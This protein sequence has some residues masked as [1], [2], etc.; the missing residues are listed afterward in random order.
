M[1][2]TQTLARRLWAAIEPI[3]AV[4]YFA[5]EPAE[6]AKKAGL[7]GFWMGYFASRVAPLGPV[8]AEAV[9][10]MAYGFAPAVVARAIPDAWRFASPSAVLE[11][12]LTS[13]PEALR[14][15]VDAA[16][17]DCAAELADLLWDGVAGC[18][19]DGRPLAAAW[20]AVPRPADP[21]AAVWLAA[22]ILR[23]H[24]GDGH[25]LA[26]VAAGLRGIDASVTFA[27]TG[28]ITRAMIQPTRGWTDEDWEQSVHRLQARGLLDRDGR[29]TKSGGALRRDVEDVTDRLAAG[30]VERLGSTGV[31]RAIDLATPVSHS[32]IDSGLIP[33][34]NPTGAPRP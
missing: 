10:A 25:V 14:H 2:P 23:E 29:L 18:R 16:V 34:P 32:L 22:T 12:R 33:V 8:P 13:A 31:E 17:L 27:A 7:R 28:A 9:G 21:V 3:H 26:G 20:S 6:A 15:H 30:P 24:R 4:A 5:P 1:E 19:F 11:A